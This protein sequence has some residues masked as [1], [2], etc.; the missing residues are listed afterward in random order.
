MFTA[1]TIAR[2]F[3]DIAQMKRNEASALRVFGSID[4][5]ISDAIAETN[6]ADAFPNVAEIVCLG[7]DECL[8]ALLSIYDPFGAPTPRGAIRLH[9]Y[10]QLKPCT[11]T[12]YIHPTEGLSH[13]VRHG[14]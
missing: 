14:E 12:W 7:G 4:A 6:Y 11:H 8:S 3:D 1:T 5:Y 2:V 10:I 13:A 9:N